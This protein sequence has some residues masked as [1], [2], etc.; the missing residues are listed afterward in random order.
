MTAAVWV[1]CLPLFSA[2]F[3]GFLGRFFLWR[4]SYFV[5]IFSLA[6]GSLLSFYLLHMTTNLGFFGVLELFPWIQMQHIQLF[7]SVK[8]D[9][10]VAV[11]LC[12]VNVISLIVHIYSMD[13]MKEDP[14]RVRFVSYISLFTFFMLLLVMANDLLQLFVGWEGVGLSSYLLIGFWHH[15]LS[16][17][18]ASLKAFVVN[19]VGD[20]ALILGIALTYMVFGTIVYDDILRALPLVKSDLFQLGGMDISVVTLITFLWFVGC[21]GKSSQIGMHIWLPDAMEGPTPVSALIHSATMVTAGVF[22]VV[23]LSA[24]FEVSEVTSI[25]M[26]VIGALTAF[27]AGTVAMTQNDIKRVVAYSTC[28]QLGFMFMGVGASAYAASLFH[29]TTH[30]FF[31]SLLFLGSGVVIHAVSNEQNIQK[32]GGLRAKLPIT[33]A[34]MAI[35]TLSLAGTPFFSGAYSK[36]AILESVWGSTLSWSSFSFWIGVMSV[37]LTALYSWRLMVLTF[38]GETRVP[39]NV[40]DHIHEAPV[41]VIIPLCF[42]GFMSIFLGGFSANSFLHTP[43]FWGH[44]LSIKTMIAEISIGQATGWVPILPTVMMII[45]SALAFASFWLYPKWPKCAVD[46]AEGLY[47]FLYNKWYFDELY[48][49]VFVTT[50]K[51]L[52]HFF[53]GAIDYGVID[54]FGPNGIS[55]SV[56]W[57]GRKIRLIQTGRVYQYAFI[58]LL[59]M[60]LFLT[61]V[62]VDKVMK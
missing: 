22:L 55:A 62:L 37:L 19:R 15:K 10:V 31:K 46:M 23:R 48:T 1:L 51:Q 20:F 61:W 17:N 57:I 30:A 21:M 27:F 13:Y 43:D 47:T 35:G 38:Y 2:I 49:K 16:A 14:G 34:L 52:G 5:G 44:A 26:L 42:L 32:M 25:L 11:M 18:A 45:G 6:V 39:K 12:V 9:T 41:F 7:W 50:S 56:G 40:F 36:D 4:I 33:H 3:S 53:G 24:V 28:S 60:T 59:S 29:L 58:L 8:V 54:R